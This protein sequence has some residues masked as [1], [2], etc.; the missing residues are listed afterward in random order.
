MDTLGGTKVAKRQSQVTCTT[1]H[2]GVSFAKNV[3]LR[4][5][6]VSVL[7]ALPSSSSSS[8]SC[9]VRCFVCCRL[10]VRAHY[11]GVSFADSTFNVF[12]TSNQHHDVIYFVCGCLSVLFHDIVVMSV[13]MTVHSVSCQRLVNI[14]I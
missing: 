2:G 9:D 4:I 6:S 7:D 12:A 14:I 1:L 10:S 8:S 3:S 5:H 13:S 11:G